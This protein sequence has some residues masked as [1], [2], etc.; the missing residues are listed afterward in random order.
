VLIIPKRNDEQFFDSCFII[1]V[2]RFYW[3]CYSN[4]LRIP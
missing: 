3:S 4:S 1:N 2:E